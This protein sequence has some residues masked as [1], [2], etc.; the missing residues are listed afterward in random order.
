MYPFTPSIYVHG[1]SHSHSLPQYT[2][3]VFH[4][5]LRKIFPVVH[6]IEF[7]TTRRSAHSLFS[8]HV[9][10]LLEV[11]EE[12]YFFICPVTLFGPYC[13]SASL[14]SPL[15]V[16]TSFPSTSLSRIPRAFHSYLKKDTHVR[17]EKVLWWTQKC[18]DE[19]SHTWIYLD[20]L[21]KSLTFRAS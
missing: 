16:E 1:L 17:K 11:E 21:S 20:F 7:K 5:K 18:Y 4:S 13:S 12:S 8:Y 10:L 19:L 2:Y 14:S 15:T 9:R 6:G 3:M